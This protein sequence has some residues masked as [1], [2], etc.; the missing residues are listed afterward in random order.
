MS[1]FIIRRSLPPAVLQNCD[2]KTIDNCQETAV[3]VKN[4]IARISILIAQ[5]PPSSHWRRSQQFT[6]H[7]VSNDIEWLHGSGFT[8]FTSQH[9]EVMYL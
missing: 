8:G 2:T 5:I 6:S 3:L 7:L 9:D 4:D 1:K